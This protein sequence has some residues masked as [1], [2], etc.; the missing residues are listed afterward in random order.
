ML[1]TTYDKHGNT[2]DNLRSSSHKLRN[3]L[4]TLSKAYDNLDTALP[5][6]DLDVALCI[7]LQ[8][9]NHYKLVEITRTS[10]PRCREGLDKPF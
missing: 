10:L 8:N 7:G 6:E 4:D 2:F 5:G 9:R 1:G 3:A